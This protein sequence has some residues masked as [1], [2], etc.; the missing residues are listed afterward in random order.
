[1]L[2]D[3]FLVLTFDPRISA[4]SNSYLVNDEHIKPNVN[5]SVT[6]VNALRG[7]LRWW[8][9]RLLLTFVQTCVIS[10]KV[11]GHHEILQCFI[12]D[13]IK[14]SI[15][16][17]GIFIKHPGSLLTVWHCSMWNHRYSIPMHCSVHVGE[18][19]GMRRLRLRSYLETIMISLLS[20]YRAPICWHCPSL[21]LPFRFPR[22]LL[23]LPA[24]LRG[25]HRHLLY[26][27]ASPSPE[28][29]SHPR[30]QICLLRLSEHLQHIRHGHG[31]YDRACLYFST[32]IMVYMTYLQ[33]LYSARASSHD[34]ISAESSQISAWDRFFCP[35]PMFSSSKTSCNMMLFNE[36]RGD[37]CWIS[38]KLKNLWNS[39][40][41]NQNLAQ[42][43]KTLKFAKLHWHL[44]TDNFGKCL[45][46]MKASNLV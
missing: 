5:H 20:Q 25:P 10:S 37:P 19:V 26:L 2:Q 29:F 34:F 32:P 22:E 30:L 27:T 16:Y 17:Q 24:Q 41:L 36:L 9:C 4:S 3:S 40:G 13:C 39:I 44:T 33:T 38:S 31:Y 35:L 43:A 15:G 12:L 18:W 8:R 14:L 7:T 45:P 46:E 28:V 21:P 1:M 11:P 23:H 6:S 42:S